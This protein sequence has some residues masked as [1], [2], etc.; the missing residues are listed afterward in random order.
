MKTYLLLAVAAFLIAAGIPSYALEGSGGKITFLGAEVQLGETAHT[1]LTITF[2]QNSTANSF[3]LPLFYEIQN[4]KAGANFGNVSCVSQKKAFGSQI[5]CAISPTP[6][7]RM[8]TLEFDSFDLIKRVDGR[9][10]YKQEFHVP[11]ETSSLSFKAILPEGM[12]LTSG[13]AFQQFLPLD[14]EKGSDGRRIFISWRKE[15]LQAGESFDTQV[16]YEALSD[17]S[18]MTALLTSGLFALGIS[19]VLL[20]SGFWLYFR[21]FRKDIKIVMPVLKSDEKTIME[22][23]LKTKG[24][25][26][27]KLLVR[28]SNYS[29]AK[30]SKILNSLRERGIVR[31]EREGRGN[32]VYIEKNFQKTGAKKQDIRKEGDENESDKG[33]PEDRSA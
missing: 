24:F 23:L 6:E 18:Q 3:S 31:L 12:F 7:K 1:A 4:L 17:N 22:L 19:I 13:G 9:F 33:K 30:V 15:R 16:S 8:L 20:V 2:D 28:E 5:D 25:S 21:R 29:K 10:L 14:G 32:K 26:N 27:Q 11:L